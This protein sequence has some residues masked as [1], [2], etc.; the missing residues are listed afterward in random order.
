M[1]IS[2]MGAYANESI[3]TDLKGFNESVFEDG[4]IYY[5]KFIKV[6]QKERVLISYYD[7]EFRITTY[8]DSGVKS[9]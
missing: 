2:S 4:T 3:P 6:N 5:S 1:L 7:E 8:N 9:L